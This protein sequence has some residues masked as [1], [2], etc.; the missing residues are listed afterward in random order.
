MKKF[1][2]L[3]FGVFLFEVFIQI[4]DLFYSNSIISIFKIITSLPLSLVNRS[5]PFYAEGSTFFGIILVTI[6]V[7]IQTLILLFIKEKLISKS[8]KHEF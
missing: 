1:I 7:I 8:T 3:F 4:I 5:Y 6:N 2:L